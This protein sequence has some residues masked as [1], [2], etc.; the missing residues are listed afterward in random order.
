MAFQTVVSLYTGSGV[1][2]EPYT[3]Y[4]MRAQS[5]TIDSASAAYNIIGSTCFT[6]LS[7]GFA[8]AGNGSGNLGF[9]GFL[10]NPKVY[11]LQGAGGNTLNPSLVLPNF[12][13]GE[14]ITEG[15]LWVLLPNTANVGD[16]V[17]YDNVTG[18]IESISP[19]TAL[20]SGKTFANAQVDYFDTGVA[21]AGQYLA[22]ISITPL[23]VGTAV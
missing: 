10:F 6:V 15:T 3:N 8:Q 5:L 22:V 17:V 12:T 18:A 7:P 16:I 20:P 13:Q 23:I 1:P 2:G 9:A 19:T 4:P 14:F 11:A 21:V